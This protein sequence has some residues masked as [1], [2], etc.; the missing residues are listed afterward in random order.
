MIA[1]FGKKLLLFLIEWGQ[2]TTLGVKTVQQ[3]LT[4]KRY[5][6]RTIDQMVFLGL[7]SLP[8]VIITATFVGM[9]FTIQV[10]REFLRF[11]AGQMI[12]GVV[13]MGI[14]RELAPMLS[15]VVIAGRVGAAISAELGT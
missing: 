6:A 11:G 8:I 14:W 7:Q 9:A 13:G 15:A 3:A 5:W 10:V 12:G 4:S 2:V 1:A